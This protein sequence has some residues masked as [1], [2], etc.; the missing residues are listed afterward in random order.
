MTLSAP[1]RPPRPGDPIE[2]KDLEALVRALIEKAR[3]RARRR[4]L[5]YAAVATS[6]ALAGVAVFVAFDRTAQSQSTSLALAARPGLAVA[7]ARSKIA[8]TTFFHV[9]RGKTVF[10]RTELYVMNPMGA[11]NEGSRR[12]S[13]SRR[14][15]AWA[16]VLS[17]RL[18]GPS[19][20]SDAAGNW[21]S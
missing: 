16:G 12:R 17:G 3:R 5:L 13:R 6:V 7:Q 18:T 10:Q 11:A 20:L 14:V 15:G 9:R 4:R 19:S 2:R 1:P 21:S 8:F